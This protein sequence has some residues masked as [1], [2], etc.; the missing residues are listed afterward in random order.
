MSISRVIKPSKIYLIVALAYEIIYREF[1]TF[2]TD[3][4]IYFPYKVSLNHP[5]FNELKNNP[6]VKYS[7]KHNAKL[8]HYIQGSGRSS[9][10]KK[11]HIILE[12]IDHALSLLAP[13]NGYKLTFNEYIQQVAIARTLYLSPELKKIIFISE[14]QKEV[15][16]KYF[17]EDIILKKSVVIPLAWLDNTEKTKSKIND[18]RNFLLIASNYQTKGVQLVLDA[19]NKYILTNPKATLTLVSHDIPKEIEESLHNS[20]ILIKEAPLPI[21][22]KD[23]LYSKSDVAIATTLTD[24]VTAIEATSY[25]KPII[26]F[27][28]Q[29][30]EDLIDN[31]NGILVDTPI[32]L[33]D[34][35]YGI[36]WK[37]ID[38]YIEFIDRFYNEGKFEFT[39]KELIDTFIAFED[40]NTLESLT[41]N[42]VAKYHKSY[43]IEVRNKMLKEIYDECYN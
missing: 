33:Y 13:Y 24:G 35:G 20:V 41:Q 8:F 23:E 38:E 16:K 37:T 42:A 7:N 31:N 14:G 26:I 29:H 22:L 25:G 1:N 17:P 43:R 19:W 12:V 2:F 11:E 5:A 9:L 6:P 15:F 30:A 21:H 27:R 28:M 40:S 32:N 10:D 4:R 39:I 18:S 3:K 36:E 34:D